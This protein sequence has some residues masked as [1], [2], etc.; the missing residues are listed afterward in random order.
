LKPQ[1]IHLEIQKVPSCSV[2]D[3]PFLAFFGNFIKL[4][5]RLRRPNISTN[6]LQFAAPSALDM[7]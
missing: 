6:A 2:S 5:N 4:G 7:A 1:S 3:N